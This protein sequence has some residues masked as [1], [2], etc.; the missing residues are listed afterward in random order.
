M[1]LG[2]IT[3][4]T[5][6]I[7]LIGAIIGGVIGGVLLTVASFVAPGTTSDQLSVAL[8]GTLFGA[9]TGAVLAPL[10]AWVFLRR[11]PLGR[12]IAHTAVGAT[13]GATLGLVIPMFG[14]WRLGGLAGGTMLIGTLVGF[15]VAAVRL[16]LKTRAP[17][18]ANV[19]DGR[20]S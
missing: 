20:T 19:S 2:R 12:A 9:A 1:R 16:R 10:T 11:V 3:A 14:L 4:V 6:S 5:A 13:I 15:L 18:T 8:I 7:A 17:A